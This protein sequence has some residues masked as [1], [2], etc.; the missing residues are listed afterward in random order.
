M[1]YIVQQEIKIAVLTAE[2]R[3]DTVQAAL[4]R[5]ATAMYE[6]C[7][8]LIVPKECLPEDFFRLGTGFAGEVL[9]K[10]S[11]YNMKIAVTGDFSG[12]KSQS[13]R[14]FIY[15]CNKGNRV[16]FKASAEEGMAALIQAAAG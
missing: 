14:D 5:M 13:L 10:F 4:D 1:N 16:F 7:V 8:G 2:E 11:N 3:L 15:E 9:Q 6:G 12:Y